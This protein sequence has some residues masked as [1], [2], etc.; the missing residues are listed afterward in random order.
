MGLDVCIAG[1]WDLQT[2]SFEIPW[3]LGYYIYNLASRKRRYQ[4]KNK[5]PSLRILDPPMEGFFLNLYDAGVF[6]GPQK[7]RQW[8]EG[9]MDP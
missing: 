9:P 4:N 2:T 6:L 7:W 5:H 1:V 3:F 8:L